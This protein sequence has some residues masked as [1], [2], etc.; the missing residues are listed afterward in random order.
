MRLRSAEI[1]VEIF[2]F[3]N[4]E[5]KMEAISIKWNLEAYGHLPF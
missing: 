2:V 5:L 4:E 1:V 3:E